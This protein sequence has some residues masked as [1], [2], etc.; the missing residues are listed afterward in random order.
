MVRQTGEHGPP[1]SRSLSISPNAVTTNE[2]STP[3]S[4]HC[5]FLIHGVWYHNVTYIN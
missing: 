2:N 5:H 1:M 3:L 4:L